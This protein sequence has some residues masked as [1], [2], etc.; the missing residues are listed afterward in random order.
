MMPEESMPEDEYIARFKARLIERW[1]RHP[2]VADD[3]ALTM[4]FDFYRR[5]VK[6]HDNPEALADDDIFFGD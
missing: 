6:F 5:S 1:G 2:E 3:W 4:N